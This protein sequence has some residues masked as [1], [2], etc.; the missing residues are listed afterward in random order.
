M[1]TPSW[2]PAVE[3][4][5]A[6]RAPLLMQQQHLQVVGGGSDELTI[7]QLMKK[8]VFWVRADRMCVY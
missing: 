4:P 8:P 6:Q 2:D 1:K 3:S 5:L 7:A